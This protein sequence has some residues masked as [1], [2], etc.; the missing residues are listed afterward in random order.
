MHTHSQI[1]AHFPRK[2]GI[3]DLERRVWLEKGYRCLY[4]LS[5]SS[6]ELFS[7]IHSNYTKTFYLVEKDRREIKTAT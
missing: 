2:T 5:I 4:S 7:Q 1:Y 6:N 3:T